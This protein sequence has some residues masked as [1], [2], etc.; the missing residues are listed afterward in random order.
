MPPTPTPHDLRTP[1]TVGQQC[2]S[3]SKREAVSVMP[4]RQGCEMQP[5]GVTCDMVPKMTTWIT[6]N[7]MPVACVSTVAYRL[8]LSLI[9]I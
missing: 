3:H 8:S 4:E 1:K 9:H 2:A 6:S 7:T 5:A